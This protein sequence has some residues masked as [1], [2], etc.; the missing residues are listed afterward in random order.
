MRRVRSMELLRAR[1][2]GSSYTLIGS[3]DPTTIGATIYTNGASGV[4]WRLKRH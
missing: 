3:G 4:Q 2:K 1:E